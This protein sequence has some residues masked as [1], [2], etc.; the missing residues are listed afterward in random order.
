MT[1]WYRDGSYRQVRPAE[2]RVKFRRYALIV[3]AAAVLLIALVALAAFL[4]PRMRRIDYVNERVVLQRPLSV[5]QLLQAR[6]DGD[7]TVFELRIMRGQ[8]EL[9]PGKPADTAGFNGTF[10]GP[11]IRA[12]RGDRIRINVTN[13]LSD[14]TTVATRT[15]CRTQ[16]PPAARKRL[17]RQVP[18]TECGGPRQLELCRTQVLDRSAQRQAGS[19]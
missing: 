15:R 8:T 4:Y 7:E 19:S 12:H 5:P 6:V 2:A 11:T 3:T 13:E 10:L 18:E 14:T 1:I 17:S 16:A 9:L